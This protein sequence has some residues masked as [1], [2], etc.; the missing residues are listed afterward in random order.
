[1][2]DNINLLPNVRKAVIHD[3]SHIDYVPSVFVYTK[4]KS[5][6]ISERLKRLQRRNLGYQ[7]EADN[8]QEREH[9][10]EVVR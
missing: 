2:S 5:T 6:Q 9:D 3:P 7:R 10:N 4:P 8:Q 1:V